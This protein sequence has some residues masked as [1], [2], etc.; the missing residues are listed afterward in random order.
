M[1]DVNNVTRKAQE[2]YY[3]SLYQEY[4]GSPMAVSSESLEHKELRFREICRLFQ[5]E[6]CPEGFSLHDTGAGLGDLYHYNRNTSSRV[7]HQILRLGH[8]G[9]VCC[10][11]E[12]TFSRH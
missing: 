6:D 10:G 8:P 7:E 9:R 1:R 2:K 4:S 3:R 5:D 12:E 11:F